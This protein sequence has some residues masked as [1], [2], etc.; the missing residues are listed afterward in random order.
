MSPTCHVQDVSAAT[1]LCILQHT[2]HI[3]FS[4]YGYIRQNP[5]F[6]YACR[7][8]SNF[9]LCESEWK[10]FDTK[11]CMTSLERALFKLDV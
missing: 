11:S 1:M 4:K 5:L 10:I 3:S 9:E 7:T 2:R 8:K 6:L